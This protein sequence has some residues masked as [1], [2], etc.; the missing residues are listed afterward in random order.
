MWLSRQCYGLQGKDWK[1]WVPLFKQLA[2]SWGPSTSGPPE[3]SHPICIPLVAPGLGFCIIF[4]C[5]PGPGRFHWILCP[6]ICS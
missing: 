3:S 6:K 1:F 4:A 5:P 2:R